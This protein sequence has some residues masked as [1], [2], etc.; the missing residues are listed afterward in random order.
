MSWRGRPRFGV[1]AALATGAL[2]ALSL[3]MGPVGPLALLAPVPLLLYALCAPRAWTV[4]VA[5]LVARAISMAGIVIV[6]DDLPLVVL[7]MWVGVVSVLYALVVL[8]ARWLARPAPGALAPFT[9]PLLLVTAEWAF[10]RLTP[11]GSFGAMGYALVDLLPLLQVASVGGMAALTFCVALVPMTVA[12]MLARPPQWR[13][14][15][16]AGALP[17]LLAGGF[18]MARLAQPYDAQVRV[19]LVGLDSQEARAYRGEAEALEAARQF[20]ALVA[21][22]A[23]ENP[24]YVV[25]PEKQ[26]GGA[27]AAGPATELLAAANTSGATVIAGFDEVLPGGERVNS[28]QVLVPGKPLTRYLKRRLIPGLELGYTTGTGPLVSDTR[29][30]AICKDLDFPDMMRE[31]GERGVDLML[32]PAWDFVRDGRLHSRMAL[33]RGVENGFAIAR[34]AAAGRLTAS[35]RY[36]RVIG[37]A[38]TSRLAP[39]SVVADLGVR[40]GGTLYSRIGDAFAWLCAALAALLLLLRARR[41]LNF[42]RAR[43]TNNAG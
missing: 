16:I 15:A 29:G 39:V 35:D 40:G 28:A 25:L 38:V 1:P 17:V 32:V 9:Y 14:V 43:L 5:A 13:R 3:D 36:G 33:V 21:R 26:L 24:A 7:L 18:G 22:V 12:V 10:A 4:A 2:L 6:Y 41:A 31:Y 19:A 34:A 42:R 11:D 27:R 37:E 23:A 8:L 20:A 30:V